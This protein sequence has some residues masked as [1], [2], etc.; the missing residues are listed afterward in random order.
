MKVL[1]QRVFDCKLRID[2]NIFSEID[3]G[4]L[5][6]LGIKVGDSEEELKYLV[7]KV[8]NLRIFEDGDG[9]MNLSVKDVGGKIMLVSQFTLYGDSTR[10]F[11]PSFSEAQRPDKAIPLYEKFK[12]SLKNE[13]I[14]VACGVFGADM[15]ITYTNDGPVSIVIEKENI[16][17]NE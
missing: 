10:G 6:Y 3:K 17:K 12:E 16:N 1:V 13:G 11:R 14:E 5:V 9:K 8:A 15:K 2:D 7:N 4:L